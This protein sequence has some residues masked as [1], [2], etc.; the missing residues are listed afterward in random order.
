VGTEPV[1]SG[2]EN[3]GI[4]YLRRESQCL[5]DHFRLIEEKWILRSDVGDNVTGD[6][7]FLFPTNLA[8][9]NYTSPRVKVISGRINQ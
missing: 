2:L 6:C 1:I 3:G 7:Q 9:L 5:E 4:G 8:K